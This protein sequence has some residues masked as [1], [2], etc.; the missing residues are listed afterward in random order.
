MSL[1][2]FGFFAVL[3]A[4]VA[5]PAE[6][7]VSP[8]T[9]RTVQTKSVEG[10]RAGKLL[11]A[12]R[13]LGDPN[14]QK[15]VILLVQYDPQGVIGL[16]L[17]R[18]TKVPLS[19]VLEDLKAAKD[20]S[21]PV[22]LGGPVQTPLVFGLLKSQAKIEGAERVFGTVYL[23]SDKTIFEK[24]ISTRPDAGNF[25]VYMGYAGWTDVQLRNEVELGAWFIFPG[26][27]S[28]VFNA[29]P[30]SLWPQ[31]IRQTEMKVAGREP[32]NAY[33]SARQEDRGGRGHGARTTTSP[34]SPGLRA[35]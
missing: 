25:H 5:F 9:F 15:T 27:V 2:N 3:A 34:G 22:Y 19:R 17:N 8:S 33:P 20:R 11:V 18:R 10:L 12:S 26:D 29:D 13:D 6:R 30:D 28:T 35:G 24:T 4:I 1:Q 21:D 7:A 32:A 31:M 16:I 23:I 14:F